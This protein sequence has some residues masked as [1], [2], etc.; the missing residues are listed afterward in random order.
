M[1]KDTRFEELTL[2]NNGWLNGKGKALDKDE[3]KRFNESFYSFYDGSL[4]LPYL[5]P[6]AEGGL[7][8]EWLIKDWDISLEIELTNLSAELHALNLQSDE[9]KE[10]DLNLVE[11]DDWQTLNEMLEGFNKEHA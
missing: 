10:L 9:E 4:P 1:L 5:Y 11:Q 6:T 7:Q 8:A 3:V 2:I